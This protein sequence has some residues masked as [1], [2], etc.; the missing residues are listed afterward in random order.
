MCNWKVPGCHLNE[1]YRVILRVSNEGITLC[2][3]ILHSPCANEKPFSMPTEKQAG[4][5]LSQFDILRK[6]QLVM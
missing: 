1:Q 6:H 3:L 5:N 4:V 2:P